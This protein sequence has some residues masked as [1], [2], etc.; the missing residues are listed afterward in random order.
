MLQPIADA[1]KLIFKEELIPADAD[2][3][4]FVLAPVIT[5]IPALI[6]TAVIPWGRRINLFG[7]TINLYLGR[8]QC[9]RAIHHRQ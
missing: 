9:G 2:K 7:R 3:L 4:I 1:V 5:V 8:Y 6:I